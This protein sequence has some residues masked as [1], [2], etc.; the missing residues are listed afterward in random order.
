MPIDDLIEQRTTRPLG[1]TATTLPR[2]DGGPRGRLSPEHQSR[3][4]Q[5][6]TDGGELFG[7][8]GNQPGYYHWPGTSQMYS[9]ARD[10][11]VFLA[12]NLGELPIDRSLQEAMALAH[13]DVLP[14]GPHN[15]QALA[16]EVCFRA[17]GRPSSRSTAVSTTPPPISGWCRAASSAL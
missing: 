9:S 1:M 11:A 14:I 15:R 4:V 13:R 2:L 12:A 17:R 7:E 8:P 5:G 6:Y 16:W 10:M 3:A